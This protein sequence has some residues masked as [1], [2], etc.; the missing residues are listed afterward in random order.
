MD[1]T[2]GPVVF[3]NS[4]ITNQDGCIRIYGRLE[5]GRSLCA[6][7]NSFYH[8]FYVDG[9]VSEVD[10]NRRVHEA[11]RKKQQTGR[12]IHAIEAVSRVPLMGY[13]PEGAVRMTK[14]TVVLPTYVSVCR[15]ILE[16][17]GRSTHEGSINYLLRYMVDKRF[18]GFDW[19][20]IDQWREVRGKE[21]SCDVEIEYHSDHLFRVGG[22]K[23]DVGSSRWLSF[24][25]EACKSGGKRGFVDAEDDPVSQIGNTIFTSKYVVLDRRVFCLR[26]DVTPRPA[27]Y[28]LE[29]FDSESEMLLAWVRY[30]VRWDCDV[31]TGYNILLFD[32]PYL[33][34]RAK[35][36]DVLG[37]FSRMGRVST[38]PATCRKTSFS[39][40]GKGAREDFSVSIEGRFVYDMLKFEKDNLMPKPRSYSL[41]NVSEK[42][43][44]FA[45][46]E[47]DYDLIPV[48]QNGTP[49]QRAHLC[50]YCWWD[51]ELCYLLAQKQMA[52][53]NYIEAARV[54][55][56]P[57]KY[58]L[59]R[60]QQ[61]LTM[62]LLLRF[63][64]AR[65]FV[66]PSSTESQNDEKT[67][68]ATVLEPKRG[69]YRDPIVTLDFQSLY[70]SIIDDSNL[71]YSTKVSLAWAKKH[72]KPDDVFVPHVT[73]PN[74]CYV[75][76]HIHKG[77]LPE[78]EAVLFLE[79]KKAKTDMNNEKD[80]DK[81]GVLNGRQ[82]AIKTRMNSLYGFLKANM[83]CDKDLMESVTGEGRFMIESSKNLVESHFKGSEVVYG[84]SVTGD[85]PCL[86]FDRETGWTIV[87]SIDTLNTV[88]WEFNGEKEYSSTGGRYLVWT[89]T[90]WT[91][92]RRIIRHR[93]GE[94]KNLVRVLT[95][96]G[97]V[98]C[99]TDHG[100]VT[101]EGVRVSS[102]E[103]TIGDS[104][105]HS[106]VPEW[107]DI[108]NI[109]NGDGPKTEKEARAW[110]FFMADGSCG[111][112][113]EG[114]TRKRTWAINK[115]D[116]PLL[117]S[118]LLDLQDSHPGVVFTILDTLESSKVYKLVA[119]GDVKSIVNRYRPHF[120]DK[121][122]YKV[123]PDIILNSPKNIRVAFWEGYYRGDGDKAFLRSDI[124][125]KIGAS[126]LFTL[127]RSIGYSVSVNTRKDKLDIYR[128]TAT[129]AT[130]R[131]KEFAI[132]KIEP[133]PSK[134]DQYVYDLETENHHFHAGV[135]QMIV[136]NTDSIFINFG[137]VS[138]EEAFRLGQI[139]AEMC[140]KLFTDGKPRHVHVLQREKLFSPFLL[141]GK[142][143]Y[144]GYKSLGPGKPFER[145]E[146]G[147]E[148]VRRD[149]ALIG[150]KT[151]DTAAEMIIVEKDYTAQRTIQYVH[152]V[153]R[154]LLMGRIEPSQL[155]ISKN[156]SKSFKHY[157][158]SGTMQPHV[159]LAKKIAARCNQTGEQPY[160]TGDRVPFVMLAG[161]K[162][163]KSSQCAEDPL[164][165]LKNRLPIDYVY[166]I[167]NQMM[168]PLLRLLMPIVAPEEQMKKR[169]KKGDKVYI[170]DSEMR[171]LKTYKALFVGPHM[172]SK[173][174]KTSG[175]MGFTTKIDSCQRCGCSVPPSVKR[176]RTEH[177]FT[178][179]TSC[180][181]KAPLV[182][183]QMRERLTQLEQKKWACWVTCQ[184]CVGERYHEAVVCA[185]RDCSNFYTRE[186]VVMDIEDLQN[187]L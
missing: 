127:L 116:K 157:E 117:E 120:Y 67:Q 102:G 70:P 75:R 96:T 11:A 175:I 124:K 16:H 182:Y 3:I 150:S 43:L 114:P 129:I 109:P 119:I 163:T 69:F 21:S 73:A 184:Q 164:Y 81:K 25:I 42:V 27:D 165:A 80:P 135:G 40:A 5:D 45:K 51:A 14:I 101:A 68:G 15:Q 169:N 145:D 48:Y 180:E 66:V 172:M 153:I 142:K 35:K 151:L 20:C 106:F 122:K 139:A 167:E 97:V 174:V 103:V 136:H 168:K 26:T 158:E 154:D 39:S 62:S 91:G 133:L 178:L 76:Q 41:G 99:T 156:L 110:G 144:T 138:V 30:I 28:H 177:R 34:K 58:L 93:L 50:Y 148:N 33:F 36:L 162:G 155:I 113:G 104:L 29:T 187:K 141:L 160:A 115:S 60:G 77:I 84:D 123:V 95:H 146:T 63:G 54:C 10:L 64:N 185:Q 186:K 83:V 78:I 179:C 166:Y 176:V 22:D 49:D 6:T 143:K 59:D 134:S 100:L 89:E 24:D 79:R 94:G 53:V 4:E 152:G 118:T 112:Y 72:L 71:C 52:I 19:L 65:N 132:K 88:E 111:T 31:I 125:G 47:M 18:G 38:I 137:S 121:D 9:D 105:L 37:E 7:T 87:K 55:G 92:I 74:Y 90:G 130:Q 159:E 13:R 56:V 12:Y 46:V 2:K 32:F 8:Y 173:V 61:I 107:P 140:T 171:E 17:E 44:G 57:L 161:L 147:L 98:D 108:V 1:K 126:G 128:L 170:S 181:P 85:T 183:L 82:L 86:V 131:K 23:S 149:N